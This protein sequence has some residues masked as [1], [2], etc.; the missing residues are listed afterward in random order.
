MYGHINEFLRLISND[1]PIHLG[2]ES[3]C[4]ILALKET[5]TPS[6]KIERRHIAVAAVLT[7]EPSSRGT[8]RQPYGLYDYR[9]NG[10]SE[11]VELPPVTVY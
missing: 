7:I 4:L 8:L 9:F 6:Q 2:E 1:S 11:G 3:C 5:D 10:D